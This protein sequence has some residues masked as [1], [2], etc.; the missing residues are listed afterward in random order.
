MAA[1]GREAGPADRDDQ[2]IRCR[3]GP[4][5]DIKLEIE[6]VLHRV[7]IE[8]GSVTVSVQ[9]GEARLSGV[10]DSTLDVELLASRLTSASAD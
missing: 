10:V 8:P 7:W 4:D 6:A 5:R 9:D 3:Q 2:E 1:T